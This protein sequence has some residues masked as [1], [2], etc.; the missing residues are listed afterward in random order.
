MVGDVPYMDVSDALAYAATVGGEVKLLADY[1]ETDIINVMPGVKLD[2][3]GNVLTANNFVLAMFGNSHI[4]DSTE[5]EGALKVTQANL[6]LMKSN[7][8]MVLETVENEF[9]FTTVVIASV[10]RYPAEN[11]AQLNF[12]LD[13]YGSSDYFVNLLKEV[14][15]ADYGVQVR[16][17]V[18]GKAATD[19]AD[20]TFYFYISESIMAQYGGHLGQLEMLV[21]GLDSLTGKIYFTPEIVSAEGTTAEVVFAGTPREYK[22]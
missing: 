6:F 5:G 8:M 4:I 21:Y 7:E 10:L 3:N 2:L 1:T 18:T 22:P 17:K 19:G 12:D 14:K 20:R 11:S 9:R 13:D 15:L 16:V